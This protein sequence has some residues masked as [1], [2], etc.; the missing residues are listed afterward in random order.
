LVR[1]TKVKR[2]KKLGGLGVLDLEL[3]SRGWDGYGTSGAIPIGHGLEL[4]SHV[5]R[6]I[7]NC[8]GHARV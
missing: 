1:W 8:S 4:M 7:N 3:F 6:Q 2:P 5:A